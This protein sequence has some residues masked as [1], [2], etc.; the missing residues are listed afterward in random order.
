MIKTLVLNRLYSNEEIFKT[1]AVSNAGG[2][3]LSVEG[4]AVRRAVVMTSGQGLH[5]AGEN[6]Y[7]DRLESGVLTYTAAGKLGEQS[8]AGV[9]NR[10]L[11]QK[12]ANF[13]IHGFALVAS[14]RDKSVGPKRWKYLGLL[15]YLRCYPDVQLDADGKVRRVWLF[16]FR[17]HSEHQALPVALDV[18]ISSQTLVESRLSAS[19]SSEDDEIISDEGQQT[20]DLER[21]EHIRGRLLSMEPRGFELF[22][23]DLLLRAGFIDVCVTKFSSDGGIDVNARAGS[24]IWIFENTLVQIQA[25]RWLHSVGRK[26][27]AELR[28]SL[29]PFARGAVVTTSHF[30]KAA[31][32]EASEEGKNPIALI[33]G[34]RLSKVVLDEGLE[35]AT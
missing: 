13:P 18:A 23:K 25:K 3:R 21:I 8:L 16:E 35:L 11:E 4:K 15:E 34:F 20:G 19:V 9:N 7:H 24:R 26:E 32:N 33:D 14:R 1:L 27:I 29:R 28:G 2:I 5:G 10:L 31:I 12:A 22:L 30:S 17:I 6:P